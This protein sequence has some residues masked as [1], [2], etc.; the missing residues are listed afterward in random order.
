MTRQTDYDPLA[1]ALRPPVDESEEEKSTRLE[2]EEA[3]KRISLEID[4]S[5]RQERQL[6]KKRNVIRVLLLGQ[7]ESGRNLF[8]ILHSFC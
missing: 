7:S 3:A 4:E 6:R 2:Q 1:K 5:I 8:W